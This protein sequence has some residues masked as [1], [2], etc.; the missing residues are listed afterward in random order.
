MR[1]NMKE[2]NLE[3]LEEVVGGMGGSPKPLPKKTG[4]H[5]YQIRSGDTL[6]KIAGRYNTTAKHLK[7][8]NSTI[9]DSRYITP[10]YYIYVPESNR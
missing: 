6:F 7:D 3:A 5:V 1:E 8:I 2:L 9:P 10:L 4:Y